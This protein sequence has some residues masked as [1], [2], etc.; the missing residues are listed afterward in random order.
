MIK[1][2][3]AGSFSW[4]ASRW[5]KHTLTLKLSQTPFPPP[6]PS[7]IMAQ[8]LWRRAN[9]RNVSFLTLYR[10][11]FTFS[12]QSLTLNYQ[13]RVCYLNEG[14]KSFPVLCKQPPLGGMPIYCKVNLS[15]LKSVCIFSTLFSMFPKEPRRRI[16]LTIQS[17]GPWSIPWFGWP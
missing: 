5:I 7:R 3:Q 9:A 16:G 17:F 13:L 4:L 2:H 12:T 15:A 10:G 11:Q 14:H 6:L 1:S 8:S